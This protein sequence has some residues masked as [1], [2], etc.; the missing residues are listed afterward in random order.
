[1]SVY[2]EAAILV[3]VMDNLNT[4]TIASLYEAFDPAMAR[5]LRPDWRFTTRPSTAV[6]STWRRQN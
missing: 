3:L 4:H 1:M 2:P 6:G 5:A